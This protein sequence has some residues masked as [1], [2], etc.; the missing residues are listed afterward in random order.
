MVCCCY[1]TIHWNKYK[2][3]KSTFDEVQFL[4][5]RTYDCITTLQLLF[6]EVVCDYEMKRKVL[7]QLYSVIFTKFEILVNELHSYT[8]EKSL[9]F[10]IN[11]LSLLIN[12]RKWSVQEAMDYIVLR[13]NVAYKELKACRQA[14][15]DS[16]LEAT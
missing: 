13:I 8:R 6:Q 11:Y 7:L 3:D 2:P 5:M 1:C 4:K 12:I 15:K 9:D 10:N 16:K 14:I